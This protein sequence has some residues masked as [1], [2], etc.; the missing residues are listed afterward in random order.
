MFGYRFNTVLSVFSQAE[1]VE[2]VSKVMTF[3][4]VMGLKS[5]LTFHA[6]NITDLFQL[7]LQV[8][9][10]SYPHTG[11]DFSFSEECVLQDR[12]KNEIHT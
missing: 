6:L 5:S 8:L 7:H 2:H 9:L 1:Y 10:G 11:L 3:Q 4:K 12:A